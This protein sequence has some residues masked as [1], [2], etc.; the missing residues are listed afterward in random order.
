MEKTMIPQRLTYSCSI[1]VVNNQESV[2]RMLREFLTRQGYR[3][4][5]SANSREAL[6]QIRRSRFDLIIVDVDLPDGGGLEFLNKIREEGGGEPVIIMAD[7]IATEQSPLESYSYAQ[8]YISKPLRLNDVASTITRALH[9]NRTG[10]PHATKPQEHERSGRHS[11]RPIS[12]ND[13]L[14]TSVSMVGQSPLML[15]LVSLIGRIAPSESSVL[16]TGATGT[17]KEL[18]ARSIHAQSRRRR[19]QFVDINCSAI[20]DTLFES[21]LFG[22]Q[23]GTFTGAHDT[24]HGLFELASGGTLFLDEVDSLSHSSQAKLLRV[25]QERK[26][27]RVGGRESI[28][29]DVR[30]IAA[31]NHDLRAAVAEGIFRPDLYFRLHVVPINVP[32]LRERKEDIPLLAEYFLSRHAAQHKKPPHRFTE[33]AMN[34]LKAYWWPGNVRELENAVEYALAICGNDELDVTDLPPGMLKVDAGEK[35]CINLES[36]ENASLAEIERRY[37]LSVFERNQQHQINTAAALGID[38]RTLYRKLCQYGTISKRKER[39]SHAESH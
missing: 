36:L 33:N 20:P 12:S 29:V 31:T 7:S 4:I 2:C 11:Q 1:L 6:E 17:G 38:R 32:E 8:G 18:V 24:R 21:E 3:F 23:R 37:I 34:A 10:L 27:R 28:N 19:G 14:Q 13:L 30:V 35:S 25:L 15:R 5:S 9:L 39:V 22:H 16:I 26:V